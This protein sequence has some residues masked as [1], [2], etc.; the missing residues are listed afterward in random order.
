MICRQMP[1]FAVPFEGEKFTILSPVTHEGTNRP[2]TMGDHLS[3]L[4]T[5]ES[6]HLEGGTQMRLRLRLTIALVLGPI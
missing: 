6:I 2:N 4:A 5:G 3:F 1:L